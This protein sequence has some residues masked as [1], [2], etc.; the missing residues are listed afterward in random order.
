MCS[1]SPLST[2][3]S[4]GEVGSATV[5][6]VVI[7]AAVEGAVVAAVVVIVI[8][9]V[10]VAGSSCGLGLEHLPSKQSWFEPR[11]R[12]LVVL[13]KVSSHNCSCT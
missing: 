7:A 2:S 10:V 8:L 11:Q 1:S 5:V 3:V 12:P 6:D 13:G 9:V 4:P